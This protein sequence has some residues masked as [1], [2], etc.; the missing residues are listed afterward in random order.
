MPSELAGAAGSLKMILIQE[1]LAPVFID[2]KAD[3]SP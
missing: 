1:L 3:S 2:K